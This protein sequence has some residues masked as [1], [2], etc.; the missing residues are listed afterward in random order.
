VHPPSQPAQKSQF[1]RSALAG[2]TIAAEDD[3][4]NLQIQE[5]AQPV[6]DSETEASTQRAQ[7]L[8]SSEISRMMNRLRNAAPLFIA[9]FNAGE[10]R[11][12]QLPW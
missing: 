10:W 4:K 11:T 7:E 3:E 5:L 6:A 9:G 8:V 1:V 12:P 2:L